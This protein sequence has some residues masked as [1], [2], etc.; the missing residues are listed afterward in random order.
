[1]S[2]ARS[3]TVVV[4]VALLACLLPSTNSAAS[5]VRAGDDVLLA[6]GKAENLSA[7]AGVLAWSHQ[8]RARTFRLA[9]R[10]AGATHDLQG[11]I[12]SR[13]LSPH[14]G[15]LSPTRPA[16]AY[17]RCQSGHCTPYAW[18]FAAHHR[19]RLAISPPS[20]CE[21]ADVAVWD[22]WL[23]YQ[24]GQR[25]GGRCPSASRGVWVRSGKERARRRAAGTLGEL[26]SG[27]IVW[28]F[29]GA[30]GAGLRIRVSSVTGH[31]RTI[32][33]SPDWSKASAVHP[34]INGTWV[35][36]AVHRAGQA[37]DDLV[38][39]PLRVPTGAQLCEDTFN[40]T[41]R[42]TIPS[43]VL[44]ADWA[45]DGPDVYYVDTF[46]EAARRGIFQVNPNRVHWAQR[47][48]DWSSPGT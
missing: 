14:V 27:Y 39:Q 2:P 44:A 43:G 10:R 36:Y 48:Y 29:E 21:V 18:D 46:S 5:A 35:I 22:S 34:T 26:R 25:Q 11:G 37:G 28:T 16:V 42:M 1:M 45:V 38:R 32:T 3:S 47:C 40:D 33:V 17:V 6:S 7:D 31:A 9:V 23:A 20:G 13:R 8:I 15:R 24:V 12:S 41:P 4:P 19:V 30:P